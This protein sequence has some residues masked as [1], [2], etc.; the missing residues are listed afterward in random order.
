MLFRS[1]R[2][3][4]QLRLTRDLLAQ[5][6]ETPAALR[7]IGTSGWVVHT[8]AAAAYCFLASPRDFERS[9]IAAVMG[10]DDADTTAAVTGAISGAFNGEEA[11][12]ARWREQVERG[13]E[14]RASALKLYDM[15][16][17][18]PVA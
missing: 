8:V 12:P 18:A 14:I 4:D 13:D 1:C 9:V 16:S 17:G 11:I 10:G 7:K 2:V 5:N 6:I 3:A 15:V